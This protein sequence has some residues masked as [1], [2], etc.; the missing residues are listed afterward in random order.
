MSQPLSQPVSQ[1]CL[2]PGDA[3]GRNAVEP[4]GSTVRFVGSCR[5]LTVAAFGFP[6]QGSWV[7]VPSSA[8]KEKPAHAV[9]ALSG[10]RTGRPDS[11]P[12]VSLGDGFEQ[13]GSRPRN[14]TQREFWVHRTARRQRLRNPSEPDRRLVVPR[15]PR[16]HHLAHLD[17]KRECHD[18]PWPGVVPA[19]AP[20]AYLETAGSP[21]NVLA[22]AGSTCQ[23]TL[24]GLVCSPLDLRMSAS[25]RANAGRLEL[26]RRNVA[27]AD[28]IARERRLRNPRTPVRCHS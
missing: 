23:V 20:V 5:S 3:H 2:S 28:N 26:P 19:I 24:P 18:K 11:Q 10:W 21:R 4:N 1:P 27:K 25:F 9:G 7:R 13:F 12:L 22:S 14:E 8:S 16:L 6:S 17:A 15:A